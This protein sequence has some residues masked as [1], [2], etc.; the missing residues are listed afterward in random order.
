MSAIRES[1]AKA[2]KKTV[3]ECRA[4]I[5]AIA[6]IPKQ[7]AG[8]GYEAIINRL[9]LRDPARRGNGMLTALAAVGLIWC[10]PRPEEALSIAANMIGTD[11][12]TIATMAGAIL[13][14]NAESDP[15]VEV[16][17]TELFIS[18]SNRLS[19]IGGW[20]RATKPSIS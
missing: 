20:P 2:W 10:E 5:L 19:A 7:E 18:E 12:D 11:T 14:V 4:A 13:G 17:D 3:D 15:P 6:E 16:L 9:M 1:F 8:K